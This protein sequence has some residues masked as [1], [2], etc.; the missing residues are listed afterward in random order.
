MKCANSATEPEM[1]H[2]SDDVGLARPA[3]THGDV[4]RYA[5]RRE[6]PP[7]RAA[8]VD[9]APLVAPSLLAHAAREL[10][11]ERTHGLAHLSQLGRRRREHVDVLETTG[12]DEPRAREALRAV[13]QPAPDLLG[14]H[15]P[16]LLQTASEIVL[17][18]LQLGRLHVGA[19]RA[20]ASAIAATSRFARSSARSTRWMK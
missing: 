14:E 10:A 5:A 15:A 13:T 19:R 1:S 3:A 17:Q 12:R 8:H 4:E 20:R 18:S 11:G 16:V 6:R 2:S 7:D 9:A